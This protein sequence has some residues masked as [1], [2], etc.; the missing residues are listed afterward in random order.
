GALF[1]TDRIIVDPRERSELA[2]KIADD[3]AAVDMES[4]GWA[5]A[6]SARG[7]PYIVVRVVS[8]TADESLPAYLARC[9]DP[10]GGIRR[11]KVL[12]HALAK[13][14]SVPRLLAMR[15]R[16]RECGERLSAFVEHFLAGVL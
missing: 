2:A 16:V 11:G 4:A 13:P 12:L 14:A 15:R 3:P 6:A 8:D 10:E 5:R 7:I 9:Y 1:S